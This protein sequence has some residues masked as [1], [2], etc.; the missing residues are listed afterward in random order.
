M[1][2]TLRPRCVRIERETERRRAGMIER[3]AELIGQ[4]QREA[5]R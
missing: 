4:I 1:T 5:H 3:K 2:S